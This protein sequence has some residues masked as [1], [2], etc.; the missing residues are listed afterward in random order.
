MFRTFLTTLIVLLLFVVSPSMAQ[1]S[2]EDSSISFLDTLVITAARTLESVREVTSNITVIEPETISASS[3]QTVSQL[4]Q[5]QGFQVRGANAGGQT[6]TMRG[7]AQQAVWSGGEMS[8]RVLILLNGRRIISNGLDFSGLANVE[9]VEIIRGSA[10]LQYGPSAMGGVVNI[11][12]RRGGPDTKIYVESGIGSYGLAKEKA[13]FSGV[14]GDFDFSVG[15]TYIDQD[16]SYRTGKGWVWQRTATGRNFNANVNMGYTINDLH[17][18]GIDYY[19]LNI[20]GDECPPSGVSHINPQDPGKPASFTYHDMYVSNIAFTYEGR[21]PSNL[22]NWSV[23]YGTG[24]NHDLA[25]GVSD[26]GAI[27]D[28]VS[29]YLFNI[30]TFTGVFSYN[31]NLIS[32]TLGVDYVKYDQYNPYNS[33]GY[34]S[35]TQ[36]NLSDIG[37]FLSAKLHLLDDRLVFSAGGRYDNYKLNAIEPYAISQKQH[38]FVPSFGVAYSPVQWLKLRANFSEGFRMPMPGELTGSPAT[39]LPNMGLK[40]EESKT[41]EIGADLYWKYVSG[42]LTYFESRYTNKIASMPVPGT[43]RPDGSG[44]PYYRNINISKQLFTGIEFAIAFDIGMALDQSFSLKPYF[45][46][47]RFFK[48]LN[49]DHNPDSPYSVENNGFDEVPNVFKTTFS[50]GITFD[51]PDYNL[52]ANLNVRKLSHGITQSWDEGLFP[53][54]YLTYSNSAIVDFSLQK[55]LISFGENLGALGLKV[56]VNNITDAYDESY[57]SYPGPGRNFYVG[58]TYTY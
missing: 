12:T 17:R 58:L 14:V 57:I 37:Y 7:Y 8:S 36:S 19:Y 27:P 3:A 9:R 23:N 56:E 32:A 50:A 51:Y 40:P 54:P 49:K 1:T 53:A 10:S 16:Q 18:I 52:S 38:N 39:T 34:N 13:A 31:G 22:F 33:P 45:N 29:L 42:S 44:Q 46:I 11:I 26:Y 24:R 5:Q 43:V 4:L 15:L 41:W 28:Y 20:Y 30:D 25:P 47:T 48:I 2:N 6:L 55:Q 21:T 35:L